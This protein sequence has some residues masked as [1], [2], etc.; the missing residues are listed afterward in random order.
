MK[1][2]TEAEL[3]RVDD[4]MPLILRTKHFLDVQGYGVHKNKVSQD[5]QSTIL[6]EKNGRQ[7]SSLWT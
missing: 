6:L 3:V 7:S 5:N 1:S 2:S 4:V